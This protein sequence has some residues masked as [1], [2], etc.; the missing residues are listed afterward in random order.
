MACAS[1]N[2]R[3]PEGRATLAPDHRF[4]EPLP[5]RIAVFRAL[6]LG[7]LLCAVPALRALRAALPRAHVTLI[8]LPWARAFVQRFAHYVDDFLP[9]PGG[10]GLPERVA[11][12]GETAAFYARARAAGFDLAIQLHGSGDRSNRVVE[13]IGARRLAGFR[14][15]RGG[16]PDPDR[17][18]AYPEPA[19]EVRR[20]VRLMDFLGAPPQGEAL[21]FPIR[22]EEW[23][24]LAELRA[25]YGLRP[26]EY[27]CIHP[28]ARAPARRWPAERFAAVADLLAAR[29]LR[30]VVTGTA[31]EEELAAAVARAMHTGSLNLAGRTPL[32]VLAA[33]LTGARLLVC[34]DTGVAHVAEALRVPSVTIYTGSSP[35]RW[36]AADRARHVSVYSPVDCRPCEHRECPIGHPCADR[37]DIES[38]W[39]AAEALL[40]RAS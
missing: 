19:T 1:Q 12:A 14:P 27:V 3:A 13:A 4:G 26:G 15:A 5:E 7:D 18:L 28:G 24:A 2:A 37:V 20:L 36:A 33:L 31:E 10:A 23:R 39:R 8:G 38:V 6:H 11:T 34:N 25:V 9:F 22:P 30:V 40:A 32:G 29:G 21:E 17:F 16:G 35:E